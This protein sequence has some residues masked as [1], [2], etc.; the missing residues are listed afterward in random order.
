VVSFRE[1]CEGAVLKLAS[2]PLTGNACWLACRGPT[3]GVTSLLLSFMYG[4]AAA[5][6]LDVVFRD[7][8]Y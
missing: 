7:Y 8:I 3:T 6:S 2:V 4:S 5:T 1:L